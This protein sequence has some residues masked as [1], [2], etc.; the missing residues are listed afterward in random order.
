M[1]KE[2]TNMN[3]S[4]SRRVS[5]DTMTR[6]Q[7]LLIFTVVHTNTKWGVG[8]ILLNYALVFVGVSFHLDHFLFI[9]KTF[10]ARLTLVLSSFS[11]DCWY[12]G[13]T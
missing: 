8:R 11:V 1:V 13:Y 7:N 10:L 9:C 6:F 2:Y 4:L 3:K 12:I 5:A